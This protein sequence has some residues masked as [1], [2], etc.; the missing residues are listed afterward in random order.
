MNDDRDVIILSR[1]APPPP[2][3][4]AALR[5][6]INYC[7]KDAAADFLD[8]SP[9]EGREGHIFPAIELIHC[10]LCEQEQRRGG[11]ER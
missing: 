4:A 11:R 1:P 10:W 7:W 9:L 3:V 5:R 8:T 6:L 2:E